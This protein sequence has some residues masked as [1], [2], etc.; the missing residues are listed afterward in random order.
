[1]SCTAGRC[2]GVDDDGDTVIADALDATHCAATHCPATHC[3]ATHGIA[4]E[5]WN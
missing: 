2:V 3:A 4:R 5:E 1:M